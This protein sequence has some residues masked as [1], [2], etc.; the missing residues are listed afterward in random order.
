MYGPSLVDELLRLA[1]LGDNTALVIIG[2]F[3]ITLGVSLGMIVF[4]Y[5]SEMKGRRL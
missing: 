2:I 4:G 1:K 3:L 5:I